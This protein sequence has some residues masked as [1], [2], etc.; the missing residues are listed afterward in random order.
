MMV[1]FFRHTM[2]VLHCCPFPVT[3]KLFPTFGKVVLFSPFPV[4]EVLSAYASRSVV[5]IAFIYI[6]LLDY[7]LCTQGCCVCAPRLFVYC[8]KVCGVCFVNR[9]VAVTIATQ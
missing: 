2:R 8:A 1:F 6:H 7:L 5:A 9:P 3:M 4:V